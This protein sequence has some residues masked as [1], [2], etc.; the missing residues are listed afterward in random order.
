MTM[1]KRWRAVVA[2]AAALLLISCSDDSAPTESPE[3]PLATLRFLNATS[4]R[5]PLD[6]S[7]GPGTPTPVEVAP[8]AWHAFEV[9]DQRPTGPNRIIWRPATGGFPSALELVV[10]RGDRVIFVAFGTS[11]SLEGGLTPD[12]AAPPRADRVNVRAI[13][14]A[15][16]RP[17]VRVYLVR[18]SQSPPGSNAVFATLSPYELPLVTSWHH[19]DAGPWRVHVVR[20]A[21]AGDETVLAS[22]EPFD[23]TLGDEVTLILHAE[24]SGYRADIIRE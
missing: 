15:T 18:A 22:S 4:D 21:P 13:L 17:L 12:T 14:V 6:V 1:R 5:A 3:L 7:V 10:R 20:Y 11:T 9:P 2:T 16:D 23:T 24:G 19:V 8:G